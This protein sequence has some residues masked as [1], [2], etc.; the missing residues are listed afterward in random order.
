MSWEN[1]IIL[2]TLGVVCVSLMQQPICME[3]VDGVGTISR[4]VNRN[5]EHNE[6][7]WIRVCSMR[8]FYSQRIFMRFSL[9]LG[10]LPAEIFKWL[11]RFFKESLKK[12]WFRTFKLNENP[13]IHNKK[14]WMRSTCDDPPYTTENSKLR[15]R[16]TRIR[17]WWWFSRHAN[18]SNS[19]NYKLAIALGKSFRR[20]PVS[21]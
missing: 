5:S 15:L 13:F 2:N 20:H 14:C 1:E 8:L 3:L 7:N 21:A 16:A 10:Q 6:D 4:G 19:F 12:F 11:I 9:K 17:L 18:N